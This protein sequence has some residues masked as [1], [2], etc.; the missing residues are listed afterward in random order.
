MI[1]KHENKKFTDPAMQ[2]AYEKHTRIPLTPDQEN[3]IGRAV[4]LA[5]EDRVRSDPHRRALREAGEPTKE[6]AE[7][8][9]KAQVVR[10]AA[11]AKRVAARIVAVK[12]ERAARGLVDAEVPRAQ[13][14]E[15][16]RA[17]EAAKIEVQQ[18]AAALRVAEAEAEVV[19]A[20]LRRVIERNTRAQAYRRYR[21]WLRAGGLLK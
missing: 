1:T 5:A 13:R 18:A 19:E 16:A 17:R 7:A 20:A 11:V 14:D 15:Q 6:E 9:A 2:A 3:E 10:D 4:I 21:L 8:L 12:A